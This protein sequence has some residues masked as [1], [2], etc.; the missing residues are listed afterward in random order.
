VLLGLLV[1]GSLA[2][3]GLAFQAVLRNPLA[4]PYVLGVSSGAA[5]GKA[6]AMLWPVSGSVAVVLWTPMW[7]FV[8]ALVP[9]IVLY[10]FAA[11][12]RRVSA[13]SLLLAGVMV[14]VSLSAVILLIQ[15]FA[16]FTKVRQMQLWWMGA[17]DVIGYGRLAGTA[18]LAA[19]AV[20]V[21]WLHARAMNLLSLDSCTAAHLG[22]DVRRTVNLLVWAASVLTALPKAPRARDL[23][24]LAEAALDA[25]RPALPA[26]ETGCWQRHLRAPRDAA[27]RLVARLRDLA[28]LAAD[29]GASLRAF[30]HAPASGVGLAWVEMARGVLIHAVRLDRARARIMAYGILAPTDWNFAADGPVAQA[31][32]AAAGD[33]TAR[34]IGAAFAPC[35]PFEV[36]PSAAVAR[37]TN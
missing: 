2:V 9:L 12:G 16:D 28:W 36:E 8:G 14:N 18:P 6:L 22:V 33:H 20:V 24:A 35:L 26:R 32:A 7:C 19:L 3:S 27:D 31:L 25:G 1:G 15:Y 10:G 34:V 29:P 21:I 30:G 11:S 13:M 37:C 17:L 5:L 4:D 23:D